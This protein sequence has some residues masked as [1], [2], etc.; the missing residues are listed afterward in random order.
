MAIDERGRLILGR[1]TGPAL[2]F[3]SEPESVFG[4]KP[5]R[6]VVL[7]S[8]YNILTTAA[9]SVPYNPRIGSVV[10]GLLF[11]PLDDITLHLIRYYAGKELSEQEPRIRVRTVLTSRTGDNKVSVSVSFQLVGDPIGEVFGANLDF[12][13]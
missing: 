3:G 1:Y 12:S 4:P 8:I 6:N 7:T 5:D 9:G 2:M 11:E 10:P 13:R